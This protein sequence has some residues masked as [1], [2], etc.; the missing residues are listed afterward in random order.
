MKQL[1]LNDWLQILGMLAIVVSLLFVGIQ[2]KQSQEIAIGAQYQE[3]ANTSIEGWR[4]RQLNPLFTRR[5]GEVEMSRHGLLPGMDEGAPA[6]ELGDR[7]IE[8]NIIILLFDNYHFQYQTGFL[9]DEYWQGQR[10]SLRRLLQLP[11]FQHYVEFHTDSYR[12]SYRQ[13]LTD[14]VGPH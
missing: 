7:Y 13:L 8:L 11:D 6:E 14:L 3:R 10:D 9:T 4:H 5:L 1:E 12:S 2:L